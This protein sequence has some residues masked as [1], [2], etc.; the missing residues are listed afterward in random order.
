M[1]FRSFGFDWETGESN[2]LLYSV[3]TGTF[4]KRMS[5]ADYN[6]K[7]NWEKAKIALVSTIDDSM[8]SSLVWLQAM[9]QPRVPYRIDGELETMQNLRILPQRLLTFR[10]VNVELQKDVVESC[11]DQKISDR[12]LDRIHQFDNADKANLVRLDKIG[13]AAGQTQVEEADFPAAFDPPRAARA[14][15]AA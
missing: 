2:I 12:I 13:K 7:R 14:A 1:L 10:R 8:K 5:A 15:S 11:L 3:G 6:A 9:S 4:R